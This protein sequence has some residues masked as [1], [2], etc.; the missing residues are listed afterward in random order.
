MSEHLRMGLMDIKYKYKC[1][2]ICIY[3]CFIH[4]F[5]LFLVSYYGFHQDLLVSVLCLRHMMLVGLIMQR[6]RR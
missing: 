5:E 2:Y 1:V 6:T 3:S 4:W